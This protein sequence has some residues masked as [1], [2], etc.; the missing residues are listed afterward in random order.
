MTERS[1]EDPAHAAHP[2]IRPHELPDTAERELLAGSSTPCCAR[3]P[4]GCAA[5]PTGT[6]VR[7]AT[8]WP[9]ARGSGP[10]ASRSTVTGVR[11][12]V[13]ARR[14]L[15]EAAARPSPAS[16]RP[17]RC[18]VPSPDPRERSGFDAFAA[19]CAEEL[20]AL[21]LQERLRG[22]VTERLAA[23]YGPG[24]ATWTGAARRPR[25]RRPR[26][27]P[28]PPP[29][30]RPAMPH[31]PRHRRTARPRTAVPPLF[32][33]RWLVLPPAAVRGR[34]TALPAWCPHPANSGC[35]P[36]R[37]PPCRCTR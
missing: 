4:T 13:R 20:A 18:C 16:R 19:E 26:R 15:L 30:T 33:L 11:R 8:G 12:E 23:A 28:P 27:L 2:G 6:A 31:R 29:S 21:R 35:P 17:W 36:S 25:L 22:D 32:G 5:P 37:A 7:T 3:T 1:S 24:A 14:P 10:S 34:P 9:C